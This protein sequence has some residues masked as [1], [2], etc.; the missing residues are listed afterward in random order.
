MS[1][2]IASSTTAQAQTSSTT[3]PHPT[4]FKVFATIHD[5]GLAVFGFAHLVV[6]Y[7]MWQAQRKC[8]QINATLGDNGK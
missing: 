7:V 6:G 2:S 3:H 5:V 4:I 1:T 8:P